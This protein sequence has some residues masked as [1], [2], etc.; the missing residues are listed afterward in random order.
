MY[1][2]LDHAKQAVRD[3]GEMISKFGLPIHY[4]PFTFAFTGTGNVAKGAVELF[5]ELP[6]EWVDYKEL[7]KLHKNYDNRKVKREPPLLF[8]TFSGSC[9]KSRVFA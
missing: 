2:S 3:I 9:L 4:G 5:K 1:P 7:S 6:H 8:S